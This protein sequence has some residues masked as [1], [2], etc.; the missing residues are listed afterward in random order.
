MS[1]KTRHSSD[2]VMTNNVTNDERLRESTD[3]GTWGYDR[4]PLCVLA[5]QEIPCFTV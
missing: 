3:H 2:L 1:R 5:C 4:W